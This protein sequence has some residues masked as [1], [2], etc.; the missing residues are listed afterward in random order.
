MQRSHLRVTKPSTGYIFIIFLLFAIACSYFSLILSAGGIVLVGVLYHV[1]KRLE[2]R[3]KR[4][5]LRYLETSNLSTDVTL[6]SSLTRFPMPA[7][8]AQAE[9]GEILW[10]NELFAEATGHHDCALKQTLRDLNPEFSTGWLVEGKPQYPEELRIG[11]QLFW[12]YGNLM[13]RD[14]D[15]NMMLMLYFV[16]CTE[17]VQLKEVYSKT[18]PIIAIISIDNYEELMKSATDSEKSSMLAQIDK[19]IYN[20]TQE[21]RCL[22]RKYDRDKYMFVLETVDFQ[23]LVEGKFSVLEEVRAIENREGVAATLS[24]GIGKEADNMQEC[25]RFAGVALDMALSRGGDQAVIK[26]KYNFDFFGGLSKELEKRTKVK[27]RV[28]ANALGQMIKDSSQVMIMGH[29]LSD[30]DC[31]G[32]AIGMACAVR[33]RE[34]PVY[35]V[36]NQEKTLS[37]DLI[38]R[39]KANPMFANIVLHP[40]DAMVKADY[41]TLLIIVDTNRPDYVESQALLESIN[42]VA[43]I[44]HH[45]R[46][47]SSIQNFALNLHE[48]SA[49][50]ASELVCEMLQYMLSTSGIN[51]TEAEALMAGLYLDT[52]GFTAKTGVRTFEAAAYLKRAGADITEVKKLF[53]NSF[54]EYMICQRITSHAKD[55]GDGII[56]AITGEDVGRVNAGKS[57]DGLLEVIGVNASIVAYQTGGDVMVSARSLGKVNVQIMME[58]LGGGGNHSAAGAQMMHTTWQEAEHQIYAAIGKYQLNFAHDKN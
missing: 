19:F 37:T 35:I 54:D 13:A 47:A 15:S 24:I 39:I 51:K 11:D 23:K 25:Y 16:C 10:T 28:V 46:A 3:K 8:V 21:S 32:A 55:A 57:A 6:H 14:D 1:S 4:E 43:V 56:V 48:P 2:R 22:L 12:V 41:N 20:W 31:V 53:M 9:T 36:L 52:K 30:M 29:K 49:S 44:D 18:R 45:R 50:S 42:K 40:D 38:E 5:I 26:T 7:L 34:R 27:S 33:N 17:F 58:Y